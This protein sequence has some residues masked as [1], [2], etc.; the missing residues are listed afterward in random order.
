MLWRSWDKQHNLHCTCPWKDKL[1]WLH[2]EDAET[3]WSICRSRSAFVAIQSLFA[4]PAKVTPSISQFSIPDMTLP[5]AD[6]ELK[7]HERQI[8]IWMYLQVRNLSHF[9]LPVEVSYFNKPSSLGNVLPIQ[10]H[11][12][13]FPEWHEYMPGKFSIAKE[14]V[15]VS[16][17]GLASSEQPLTAIFCCP[18]GEGRNM[19]GWAPSD[20][21][22]FTPSFR[23]EL[24]LLDLLPP[25]FPMPWDTMFKTAVFKW[26]RQRLR[27]QWVLQD[28]LLPFHTMKYDC[29]PGSVSRKAR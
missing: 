27:R 17:K 15:L 13:L 7:G 19:Y 11:D 3:S 20:L 26:L 6:V 23:A 22:H 25:D 28:S 12:I 8:T 9:M 4:I 1:M 16:P 21:Y 5:R 24:L 10:Q 29:L 18:P 2:K 14:A